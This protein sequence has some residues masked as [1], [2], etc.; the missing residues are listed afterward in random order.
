MPLGATVSFALVGERPIPPIEPLLITPMATLR[1]NQLALFFF[2][3]A[4]SLVSTGRGGVGINTV[5]LARLISL[6]VTF[7]QLFLCSL[8][9]TPAGNYPPP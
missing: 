9:A 8:P 2:V 5:R 1:P 3:H 6:E 4:H 7:S